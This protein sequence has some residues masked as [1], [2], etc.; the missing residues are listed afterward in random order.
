MLDMTKKVVE[1][2]MRRYLADT[3]MSSNVIK[4]IWL[5]NEK[6]GLSSFTRITWPKMKKLMNYQQPARD[7]ENDEALMHW[8]DDADVEH[9]P[10]TPVQEN[11]KEAEEADAK[12][13]E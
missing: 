13:N 10:V 8:P 6:N 11:E 4:K 5:G 12:E 2:S 9:Q 7:K 1:N 3:D